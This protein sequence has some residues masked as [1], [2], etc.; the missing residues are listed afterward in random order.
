MI[1]VTGADSSESERE[2]QR[3]TLKRTNQV[4]RIE[5]WHLEH[6][7]YWRLKAIDLCFVRDKFIA[8]RPDHVSERVATNL[9]LRK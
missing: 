3:F 8:T 1:G 2:E 6:R 4:V 7:F 9:T 5:A